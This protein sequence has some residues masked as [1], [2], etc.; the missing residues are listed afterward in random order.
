MPLNP[1]MLKVTCIYLYLPETNVT[2]IA[3]LYGICGQ[4]S[5]KPVIPVLYKLNVSLPVHNEKISSRRSFTLGTLA[6]PLREYLAVSIPPKSLCAA[7]IE[8]KKQAEMVTSDPSLKRV[9][10]LLVCQSLYQLPPPQL[11][12]P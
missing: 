3:C 6:A 10:T 1:K 2:T 9:P 4:L 12:Q 7:E 11:C 8:K 5:F